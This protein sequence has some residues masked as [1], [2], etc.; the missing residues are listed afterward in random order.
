[1]PPMISSPPEIRGASEVVLS[2]S[3]HHPSHAVGFSWALCLVSSTGSFPM[4]FHSLSSY[5]EFPLLWHLN[6]KLAHISWDFAILAY[7][8]GIVMS[9]VSNITKVT[10]LE[11]ILGK[12]HVHWS[13]YR[14]GSQLS[15]LRLHLVS[16]ICPGSLCPV[17]TVEQNMPG[18]DFCTRL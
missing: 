10:K 16:H 3:A 7:W 2:R 6:L 18:A 9:L 14:G 8:W 17:T 12:W 15:P 5:W 1:M 4:S 11:F 13:F